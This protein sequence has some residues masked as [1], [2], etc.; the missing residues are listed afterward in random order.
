MRNLAIAMLIIALPCISSAQ[1]NRADS[2]DVSIS[3]IFQDSKS[4][5]GDGGSSLDVD[6]DTGFGV[7]FAYNWS[8][9]LSFGMDFEFLQPD[10]KATLVD[11]NGVLNDI[12]IDH[13]MSQFNGRFKGTFNFIEGSLHRFS[14]R[15]WGGATLTQM[16]R[17][18]LRK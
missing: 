9:K 2:W 16:C 6:S 18:G 10:Y 13:E 15:G 12:V 7:N 3:A 17:T 1:G 4:I 8:S 11:A 14:K 5:G